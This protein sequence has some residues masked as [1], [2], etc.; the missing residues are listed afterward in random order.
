MKRPR[1]AI[2]LAAGQGV[3]MRSAIPKPLHHVGGRPMADWV[4]ALAREAGC[5]RIAFVVGKDSEAL[6]AYAG[7]ALGPAAAVVQ[8]PPLG[9]AHAVRAAE[10]ALADFDGDAVV[11]FAADPLMRAETLQKA[12]AARTAGADLVV[13]G[14]E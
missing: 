9:T 8:N 1:A 4:V 13:V 10:A 14:F 11:L 7:E 2:I 12:F 3:R 5:D 6:R